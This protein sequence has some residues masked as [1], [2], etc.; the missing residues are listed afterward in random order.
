[1]S[2]SESQASGHASQALS[3][4][5]APAPLWILTG[6]TACGKTALA[7]ALAALHRQRGLPPI[8][9]ISVDSALIYRGMDVG[10]AKPSAQELAA[11]PHHLI[12]ILDPTQRYSAAQFRDDA[13]A[14]M[15]A[16]HARGHQP[17]FVGGTMLY[18]KA[19][20]EGLDSMPSVSPQVRASVAQRM[21]EHGSAHMHAA[22]KVVD[23][24]TAARLAPADSQRIQRAWEVWEASGQALSSFQLG[25]EGR[26]A[27]LPARVVSLEPRQRAWLHQ[28]IAW[29][30]M[31]MMANG[32]VQEVRALRAR[33]DLHADLPAMRAVGY[34]Q[35]WQA[36]AQ[37]VDLSQRQA[38]LSVCEQGIAAT[39]QL[40]KRQHTWLRSMPE[41]LVLPCDAPLSAQELGPPGVSA[42]QVAPAAI[43][44]QLLAPQALAHFLAPDL[45]Q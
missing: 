33:S 21:R 17:I 10:T 39:R 26:S 42:T 19:L 7:L 20:I 3:Q 15:H 40:A 36:L 29:R 38:A 34:R 43:E 27:P 24:P 8:E 25:A 22:L 35:V 13:L 2:T 1:M 5:A 41:R 14:C 4:S 32:F 45:A 28:R 30:F 9:V 6:P 31:H 44:P 23:A 12:D 16:I 37:G 18:I 11:V